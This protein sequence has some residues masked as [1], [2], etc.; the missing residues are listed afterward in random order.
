MI[1]YAPAANCWNPKL[2]GL[3]IPINGIYN[4]WRMEDAWLD[5]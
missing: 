2:K 3:T 4:G 5:N 1:F